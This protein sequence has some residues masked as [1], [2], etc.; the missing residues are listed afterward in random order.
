MQDR[1][2]GDIGDFAKYS[3]LNAIARGRKLGVAWYHHPD[4]AHNSDG[5]HTKYLKYPEIWRPLDPKVFDT[6]AQLVSNNDRN[7]KSLIESGCLFASAYSTE[8]L[9]FNDPSF[10]RRSDWRTAWFERVC[11]DLNACDIVFADPDNGLRCDEAFRAGRRKNWK[12]LPESEALVLARNRTAVIYHHNSRYPGGHA[13]EIR[14]WMNRL[15]CS[16][17]VRMRRF[18]S[19]TFFVLNGEPET[20]ERAK[21]W[22]CKFGKGYEVVLR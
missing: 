4:E 6:L 15:Q 21:L 14:F 8:T 17:A 16:F 22:V 10:Q 5:K 18:S 20:L 11:R 2:V 1:Y 12:S 9:G 3:F 19:R 7:L 13:E